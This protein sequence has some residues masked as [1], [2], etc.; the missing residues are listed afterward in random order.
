MAS[1]GLSN[2]RGP[3]RRPKVCKSDPN[4]GRCHPPPPPSAVSCSL[5]KDEPIPIYVEEDFT[6]LWEG[7]NEA[8]PNDLMLSPQVETTIGTI[9]E[10]EDGENCQTEHNVMWTAPDDPGQ[11]VMTLTVT[12]P[13]ASECISTLDIV[14][15]E[16]PNGD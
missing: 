12:W 1:N 8:Y 3:L 4:P 14:V 9:N 5:R 7:C 10:V 16:E 11:G 2:R 6:F 13:D 15:E